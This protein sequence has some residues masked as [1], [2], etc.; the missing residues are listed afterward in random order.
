MKEFVYFL[1]GQPPYDSLDLDDLER[2]ADS[3]E[4]EYFPAGAQ[5]VTAGQ[6]PLRHLW[7]VRTGSVEVLDRERV[8]DQL[9]VGD[10][11]GQVSLFSGEPPALSVRALED[12]LVY[13]V[14]DPRTVVSRPE[15][16]RF[17]PYGSLVQK[18]RVS[19][20]PTGLRDRALV[21]VSTYGRPLVRCAAGDSIADVA[22]RIGREHQSC[23]VV[24]FPDGFGIVT[25]ADFRKRVGTGEAA[26]HDPIGR[27][28]TRPALTV[29][30]D[31][32]L[33]SAFLEMVER[34]VHHLVLTDGAELPTGV[35]R[36]VDLASA[37]VRDPLVV[38]TA[39]DS[40]ATLE[41]LA[42]AV[43]LLPGTA[44]EL[45]DAAV[46]PVRIGALLSAVLDSVLRRLLTL[47]PMDVGVRTSWIV[48]GSLARREVLPT[49]DV[50]TAL[51]WEDPPEG[52]GDLAAQVRRAASGVLDDLERTG[53]RRC[54][55][56]A[57]AD[58]ARFSRSV[59]GWRE[60]TAG[61]LRD[62]GQD[63]ALLLSTMLA[64]SRPIS[65]VALGTTVT[66]RLMSTTRT[67][68]F[69]RMLLE[70]TL[71]SRPPTGFVRDFVVEHSGEHRGQLNLKR[72]G[73]RPVTSLGRWVAVVTGDVRGTTPERLR[74][75]ADAKLLTADE[76]ESL[77]GAHEQIYGLLL[78]M[79]VEA[80]R[81][82]TPVSTYVAPAKL[83]SLTRR[84]LR[85]S[86]RA[87]ANVQSR[88]DSNW[89]GT[90]PGMSS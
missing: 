58:N 19:A 88:L 34:G 1:G 85:E 41:E 38:R 56:G 54:A 48:L 61:W 75:A 53:L 20:S 40:A 57:N 13:R 42:Q 36:V 66:E 60:A 84:H 68:Q 46:P 27:L 35:V 30:E 39:I 43:A 21:P 67:P 33:A 82:S 87:I 17:T 25:D 89:Q 2:L 6:E 8:I 80:L 70:Y 55:D 65:S 69:L 77:I 24:T 3:I 29:P 47:S 26:P 50:D 64:D 76:S 22:D 4:A 90:L 52:T 10:T 37:E 18:A 79:E 15:R 7:V 62:A 72:G 32:P 83:D 23:A 11:F 5:I 44:V 31:T 71:S 73:L 51:V 12:C 45:F 78:Q 59:S 86:F 28:A 14:P 9:H 49:S 81:T 63:S 74:R 16:L